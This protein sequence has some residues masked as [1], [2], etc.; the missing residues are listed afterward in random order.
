MGP[1]TCVHPPL[2]LIPERR[3]REH[4]CASYLN[5]PAGR[6]TPSSAHAASGRQLLRTSQTL[7]TTYETDSDD[8]NLTNTHIVQISRLQQQV[9]A[10]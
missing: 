8:S 9:R 1:W 7:D 10:S 4:V 2:R 6:S 5:R 3:H